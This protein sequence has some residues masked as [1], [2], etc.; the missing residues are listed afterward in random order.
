[1]SAM[2]DKIGAAILDEG[3][4][5]GALAHHPTGEYS[6]ERRLARA[7]IEALREPT[8]EMVSKL[9]VEMVLPG[10]ARDA[11]KALIDAA[12]KESA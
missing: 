8:D 1:M 2:V 7:A 9:A 4:N 6:I 11:W 10:K 5:F 3:R 12:L